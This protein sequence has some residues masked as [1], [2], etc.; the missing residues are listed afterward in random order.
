M[1]VLTVELSTLLPDIEAHKY[2]INKQVEIS[3][4]CAGHFDW[5]ELKANQTTGNQ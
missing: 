4:F 2:H 1:K 5:V 3:L